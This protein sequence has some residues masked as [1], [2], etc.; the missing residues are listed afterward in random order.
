VPALG[1]VRAVARAARRTGLRGLLLLGVLFGLV[2]GVVLGT[3]A[4][5]ERTRGAYPRLVDA[6]GL[7]DARVAVAADQPQLLADVR[8]LPG[9]REAWATYSWVAQVRGQSLLFVSIGAGQNQ[10][11]DLLHPVLVAGRTPAPD[12]PDEVLVSEPLAERRGL[13]VGSR[14]PVALLTLRQVSD[15][16]VGFGPPEG[17]STELTVVGVGR[18]PAWGGAL[19]NVL[20]GPAFAQR[21][22]GYAA[23]RPVFVRLTD[24]PGSAA[25]FTAGFTAAAARADAVSRSI[26]ADYVPRTVELPR[27]DADPAL[28]T[29]E[30]TLVVGLAVVAAVL[31]MGG[32]VVVGQGVGRHHQ[33]RREP[34]LVESALGMGA[35][36]RVTARLLAAAPAAV[37]AALLAGALGLAAGRLEPLGSLARFE[38]E[39]GLRPPWAIAAVGAVATA[40]LFLAIVGVAAA[41]TGS[42]R[43][44]RPPAVRPAV[45]WWSRWPAVTVGVRMA[46]R[47]RGGGPGAVMAVAVAVLSV[48]GIVATLAFGASVDRLVHEPARY[49]QAADLT[50]VDAREP[51]MARL[52][53][54]PRVA[55]LATVYSSTVLLADGRPLPGSAA[56]ARKGVIPVAVATGRLPTGYGEIALSPRVARELGVGVGDV[57]PV[58]TSGL[59]P[60]DFRVVGTVAVV[61]EGGGLGDGALVAP[62]QLGQVSQGVPLVS[63]QIVAAPGRA[64]ALAADLGRD[65]ELSGREMPAE[66]RN[67]ADLL[68]LPEILAVTLTLVAGLALAHSLLS[69][70]R[71]HRRELTVLAALG[72]TP[73]QVRATLAVLAATTVVPAL[74]LGVPLGLGIARVLWWQVATSIGV[75]GELS[76]PWGVL[77]VAAPIA[78][79]AAL[80]LAVL[81]RAARAAA[82]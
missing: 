2:A 22:A 80:V 52:V 7:D 46:V 38:P 56:V 23:A 73:G 16:D 44:R 72:A 35:G 69:A 42:V 47:G 61:D 48:A 24:D 77:A 4:L 9:V 21:H 25:A 1:A 49:G 39:P 5:A 8:R 33:L 10:P 3:V 54:D 11:A 41:V 63:A 78:L 20:A 45:T 12:A 37:V 29:T 34:Q 68:R 82:R 76:V 14:I 65:L 27:S 81:P 19:A 75:S 59:R 60:I 55:A 26:V 28:A 70:A 6:V 58:Q 13:T 67:L 32:A 43:R 36:Q 50:V 74:L 57:L 62:L 66:V 51:D 17:P 64:D 79:G 18:M 71:R 40:A 30:Q 31:G 15:F 53:G